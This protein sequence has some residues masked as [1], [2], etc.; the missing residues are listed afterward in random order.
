MLCHITPILLPLCLLHTPRFLLL[1]PLFA[2]KSC[3]YLLPIHWLLSFFIT[4]IAAIHIHTAH[5]IPQPWVMF[6][7]IQ[8]CFCGVHVSQ[9]PAMCKVKPL[10]TCP[11]RDDREALGDMSIQR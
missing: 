8:K 9:I 7:K 3:L 6:T 10:G 1:L 2:R 11:S 4:P 5:N